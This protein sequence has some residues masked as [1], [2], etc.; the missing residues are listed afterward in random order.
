MTYVR[1]TEELFGVFGLYEGKRQEVFTAK[2]YDEARQIKRDYTREEPFRPFY[3]GRYTA[4]I[5]A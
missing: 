4:K 2:T 3:I 1:K 5:V